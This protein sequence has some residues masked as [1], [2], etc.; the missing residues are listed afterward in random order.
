MRKAGYVSKRDNAESA[1][2]LYI[3]RAA[4]KEPWT[5]TTE[6]QRAIE[7]ECHLSHSRETLV[8]DCMYCLRKYNEV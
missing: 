4:G 3:V 7:Y 1:Y 5:R 2:K 8:T 6:E